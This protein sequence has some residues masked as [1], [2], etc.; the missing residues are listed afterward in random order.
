MRE[1]SVICSTF[2][3]KVFAV[4]LNIE[5][6]AKHV[7]F[8][9]FLILMFLPE[10]LLLFN[11]SFRQWIK[12]G[13]EDADGKFEKSDLASL[14]IHYSTLWCTRLY[15]MFGLLEAFY[16]VQIRDVYVVGSL[17]GAFGIEAVGFLLKKY[18]NK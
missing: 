18:P 7:L 2:L 4:V 12:T 14:I 10:L 8:L 5:S 15:V 16:S 6:N 9:V 11:K 3:L 13:I 17:V 1:L